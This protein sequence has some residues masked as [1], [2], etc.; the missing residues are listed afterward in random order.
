[1]QAELIDR[2]RLEYLE[3]MSLKIASINLRKHQHLQIFW[4]KFQ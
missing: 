2:V 4:K 1:M 3:P